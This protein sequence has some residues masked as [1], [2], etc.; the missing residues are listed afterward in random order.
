MYSSR[1]AG[2]SHRDRRRGEPRRGDCRVQGLAA[3]WAPGSGLFASAARLDD[4]ERLVRSAAAALPNDAG[5]PSRA[6]SPPTRP[7]LGPLCRGALL[8]GPPDWAGPRTGPRPASCTWRSTSRSRWSVAMGAPCSTAAAAVACGCRPTGRWWRGSFRRTASGSKAW[9]TSWPSVHAH[10]GTSLPPGRAG[11]PSCSPRGW[12]EC[13]STS[14]SGT[15]W[16]RT[17]SRANRPSLHAPTSGRA[18]GG[19]GARRPPPG[20]TGLEI[21]R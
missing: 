11:A 10:A 13:S 21:R 1:A 18:R 19:H 14:W 2:A 15:R 12:E 20:S 6:C 8:L 16:R 7:N 5:R 3:E 4:I 17:A 9:R